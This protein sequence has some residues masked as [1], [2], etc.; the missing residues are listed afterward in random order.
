[1]SRGGTVDRLLQF[2]ANLDREKDGGD[3]RQIEVLRLVRIH[4]VV[5]YLADRPMQRAAEGCDYDRE[6]EIKCAAFGMLYCLLN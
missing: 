1:M 2:W 6:R 4:V 5:W 3:S